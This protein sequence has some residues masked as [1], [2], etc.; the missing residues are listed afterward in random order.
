V[1][2]HR[3]QPD[4]P[5]PSPL[6]GG[7]DAAARPADPPTAAAHLAALD[8]ASAE[9]ARIRLREQGIVPIEPDPRV[10]VM[11]GGDEQVVAVRRSVAVERR[12]GWRDP[13]GGIAGDLYVTTRRLLHL[14]RVDVEYPLSSIR[15]ALV[16]DTA[17]LLTVGDDRGLAIRVEDT[18]VLRV[19]IGAARE[20]RRALDGASSAGLPGD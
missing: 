12:S 19:E 15:E 14:G 9:A 16:A 20:V 8:E 11:L 18:R 10:A 2:R 7:G 17:L 4:P 3:R 6:P 1:E 13:D 5:S